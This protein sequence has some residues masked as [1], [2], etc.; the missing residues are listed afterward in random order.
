MKT[1]LRIGA[2]ALLALAIPLPGGAVAQS[3][4]APTRPAIRGNFV[5]FDH[6]YAERDLNGERVGILHIYSEA[7]D[8]RFAIEPREGYTCVDDVARGIVLLAATNPDAKRRHR[9]EML[10]RFVLRMQAEN[11]YFHNF[12][13]GDGR[14]NRDYRTSL[15]ELNW[16]SLRA[17]WGL[18]AALPHLAPDTAAR[19]RTAADRL[20][21]NLQRDLPVSASGTTTVAGLTVPTW[22]PLESGA[23]A[24]SVALLGLLPHWQR[25]RD[26]ATRALI[27]RIG[28]GLV[29]MQA[30]DARRFPHGAFLSWQNRWHAWG[31]AQAYALLR[32]GKLLGRA[33][34]T[35]S[36]LREVDHF[37]PWLLKTGMR[38]AFALQK[39][40]QGFKAVEA[41]RFPQ[42][43]YGITPMILAATE[44]HR[45]TG[46]GRYQLL[47]Q[48][49]GMWFAG[50][51]D[52]RQ[53][54]LDP[55]TGRGYDGIIAP[56]RINPN[57]GAESTIEGLFAATALAG[58][59]L[60]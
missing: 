40:G 53:V 29:A 30:G 15:A 45:Q 23:D 57:A 52:A 10:T 41:E 24:G 1:T 49:L 35:A 36:A 32:A 3:I 47:A 37:Y 18:E 60:P 39:D 46:E 42:I 48:R 11:G 43:A 14:I 25:T 2:A 7:P 58:T 22:L 50:R 54:M 12:L 38:S 20:V 31:N 21:A 9:I 5:H 59:P 17:L 28:D 33:D 56:D 51:N 34:F 27:G 6:L 8:Y 4:A 55:A 26:P 44:A 16:W 13:W 19:A